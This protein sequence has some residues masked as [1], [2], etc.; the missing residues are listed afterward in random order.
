MLGLSRKGV[1]QSL[2]SLQEPGLIR[3]H[4]GQ[5]EFLDLSALEAQGHVEICTWQHAQNPTPPGMV[6]GA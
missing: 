4:H 5:T 2:R 3:I 1:S 6:Q